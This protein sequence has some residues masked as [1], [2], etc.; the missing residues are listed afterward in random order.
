LTNELDIHRHSQ[1]AW[2][3]IYAVL[4]LPLFHAFGSA[5]FYSAVIAVGRDPMAQYYYFLASL[6]ILGLIPCLIFVLSG[7]SR[8]ADLGMAFGNWKYGLITVALGLPVMLVIAYFT[9]R[10]PSFRNEY[11]LF[12]DLLIY[13]NGLPGYFGMYALYYIGWETFFRG[14]MLFGLRP[15]VG[16]LNSILLQ[17]IPSCLLHIGKPQ[18]EFF[19]S[20]IGG[21]CFGWVALRCR[22]FWP[23]FI[24]HFG[25]GIFVDLFIIYG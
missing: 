25:L 20:L 14:I 6:L 2:I 11:P 24:C 12:R 10:D 3:L 16:D 19:G 4:A 8:A 13:R 21:L 18:P 9:S 17:T 1:V 15:A 23:I 22:S 7:K 5:K